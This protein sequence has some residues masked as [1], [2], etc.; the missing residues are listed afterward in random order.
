MNKNLRKAMISAICMLI[1]GV[2]SLTG[3]TY[4]W[5]TSS[6]AATVTGMTFDVYTPVGGVLISDTYNTNWG[7]S[8]KLNDANFKDFM[9]VS[10]ADVVVGGKLNFFAAEVNTAPTI[11]ALG[12]EIRTSAAGDGAYFAKTIYLYNDGAEDVTVNLAGTSIAVNT[13]DG[14]KDHGAQ[15]AMR[16]A[17]VKHGQYDQNEAAPALSGGDVAIYEPN[18]TTHVDATVSGQKAY[19]GIIGASGNTWFDSTD[20]DTNSTLCKSVTTVVNASDLSVEV[21]TGMCYAVTVYIWL[22]G[23]DVDCVN[24]VG[25]TNLMAE[26]HFTKA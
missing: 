14:S 22:E 12:D 25:G 15:N 21:K 5:F 26:I 24:K 19:N 17:L 18:A 7:Y 23:Q 10:T 2:M 6:N 4:A 16:L 20:A 9:P 8:L 1:V 13:A 3:V 11:G